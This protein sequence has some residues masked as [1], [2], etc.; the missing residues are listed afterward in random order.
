MM[1]NQT[2]GES[3]AYSGIAVLVLFGLAVASN[4]AGSELAANETAP[5]A[6]DDPVDFAAA[7][8]ARE[9]VLRL[10]AFNIPEVIV[11]DRK[12]SEQCL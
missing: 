3:R 12:D 7:A 9:V 1:S 2:S 6:F 8:V 4:H 5:S 11:I 10:P